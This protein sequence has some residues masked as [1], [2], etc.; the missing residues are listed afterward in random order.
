MHEIW[1][2]HSGVTTLLFTGFL[3]NT[4]GCLPPGTHCHQSGWVAYRKQ[5]PVSCATQCIRSWKLVNA[6]FHRHQVL[7]FQFWLQYQCFYVIKAIHLVNNPLVNTHQL[8]SW[9]AALWPGWSFL[10]RQC[11]TSP[12]PHHAPSA[13]PPSLQM[14]S[15][16]TWMTP[17]KDEQAYNEIHTEI[18]PVLWHITWMHIKTRWTKK[19]RWQCTTTT[20][21]HTCRVVT[22]LLHGAESFL[23]S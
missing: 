7:K 4:R 14:L 16:K 15:R 3:E 12:L 22:Y 9:T 6:H 5:Q 8:H 1:G 23:R 17:M 20:N 2:F 18:M 13:N 10:P 21:G 19:Y 11:S